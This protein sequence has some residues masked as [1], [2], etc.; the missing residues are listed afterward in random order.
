MKKKLQKY[1]IDNQLF[2]QADKILVAVSGGIDSMLLLTFL[3]ELGYQIGVAHVNYGKRGADSDADEALVQ[4]WASARKI[5]FWARKYDEKTEV[6][7]GGS[8]Q[9]RARNFRYEWFEYLCQT[10]DYQYI[11]TAHHADDNTETALMNLAR[12][13]GLRGLVAMLPKQGRVVRPLLW[14]Q[15]SLLLAT[16]ISQKIPFRHDVSNDTNDY[17]RNFVRHEIV[18]KLE[19]LNANFA[20]TMLQ[21]QQ[22][23]NES[24]TF[25]D[26]FLTPILKELI[27]VESEFVTKIKTC[28]LKKYPAPRLILF[29]CLKPFNF[30]NLQIDKIFEASQSQTASGKRFDSETHELFLHHGNIEIHLKNTPTE[31]VDFLPK[32]ID[33]TNMQP[34]QVIK[35]E[36][37]IFSLKEKNLDFQFNKEK[38][39]AYLDFEKLNFPLTLRTAQKGDFFQPLGMNGKSK[40]ISDFFTQTKFSFQ[41]KQHQKIL[42]HKDGTEI[43]WIIGQRSDERSKVGEGTRWVLCMEVADF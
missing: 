40:K 2:T 29:E 17:D 25:I 21:N 15:K 37:L 3:Y 19:H 33:L 7:R 43:L 41:K 18:P 32:S 14:V 9:A 28:E 5:P 24:Q 16:A 1:I 35:F 34:N 4:A 22:Y 23:F 38:N 8:F 10:F 36:N 12:G 42:T 39:L 30:K 31:G 11:A 26:F 13:T 20:V 27:E 6:L